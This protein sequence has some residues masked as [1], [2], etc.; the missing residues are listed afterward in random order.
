[1]NIYR[2]QFAS[3]CPADGEYIVYSVEIQSKQMI[4]VEEINAAIETERKAFH[5]AIADRLFKE[6]GGVQKITAV[7]QGV[8]IETMRGAW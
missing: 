7:H 3:I 2:R 8:E 5:E 6:F 1:M 4:R